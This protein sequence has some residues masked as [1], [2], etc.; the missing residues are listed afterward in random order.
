M[1]HI[2]PQPQLLFVAICA[3]LLAVP[4]ADLSAQETPTGQKM[5]LLVGVKKYD[6]EQLR[7]LHFAEND[8][9]ELA[10]VLKGQ[11]YQVVLLTTKQGEKDSRWKPT[12]ENIRQQ[13]NAMLTKVTKRDLVLV[14]L[15]GHGLQPLGSDQSYFCPVD[16]D[17]TTRQGIGKEP[18]VV[19][20]SETLISIDSLLQTLDESGVGQKLLLV[21]ACRNDPGVKGRRGVDAVR[22]QSLPTE[23]V[24]LLSC[25]AGQFAF[26]HKSWGSGGHGAFFA[27]VIEGLS[28]KAADESGQ[29]TW[30][31]LDYYVGKRVPQRVKEV[32]GKDGGEQRPQIIANFS[33]EPLILVSVS[34]TKRPVTDLPV[35]NPSGGTEIGDISNLRQTLAVLALQVSKQL[36]DHDRPTISLGQFTGPPNFPSSSSPGIVKILTEEFERNGVLVK[37]RAN[38]EIKGEYMVDEVTSVDINLADRKFLAIKIICTVV[39]RL[40]KVATDFTFN[41]PLDN[42]N[43]ARLAQGKFTTYVTGEANFTGLLGLPAALRAGDLSADRDDNLR[44]Y[45]ADPPSHVA[46]QYRCS[47]DRE[48]PFALEILVNGQPRPITIENGLPFVKIQSHETYQI[49][50]HNDA[51]HDVALRI[52]IDGLSVF[53]FSSLLHTD[54][55]RRGQ[56]LYTEY[57]IPRRSFRTIKGWHKT[58]ES[59]DSFMVTEYSKSAAAEL[60]STE[61]L[62]TITA[63]FHAAW[64]EDGP[65]PHD[66]PASRKG[67]PNATGFGP[68][69]DQKVEIVRRR[70]GV[71][72]ATVSIRYSK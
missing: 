33:A 55:P 57:I 54:G 72:R 49:R 7:N 62:G 34:G 2:E 45:V 11:G 51:E 41:G 43:R 22:V 61:N 10:D 37:G 18:A 25:S 3:L 39:D 56:P 9:E 65:P 58:N 69:V 46:A 29:V 68:R 44:R 59:V 48:S 15:A 60:K 52:A 12:V 70:I 50:V 13:M 5:A 32:Y 28:G 42:E 64:S 6:H 30:K 14:G 47:A 63:C 36:S 19:T 24:V 21:D 16:A 67:T 40:G 23:T 35:K 53:A 71:L 4:S 20:R 31:N 8:V 17:P 38:Y 1:R 66:E 27:T 26:E